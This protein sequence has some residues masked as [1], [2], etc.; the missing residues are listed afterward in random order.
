MKSEN[1]LNSTGHITQLDGI[2]ALAA[3]MVMYFHFFEWHIIGGTFINN[4]IQKTSLY[5]QTGVS[6]FFLLSGF[7]ITRILLSNKNKPD[8]FKNF[9]VKRILRIAPLYYFFLLV[10]YY[11][12][13]Y[14][15][16]GEV[17][18]IKD[19]IIYS[20]YLQNIYLTFSN[21]IKGPG[22]FW[23]LAVEEH[24]YLFWPLLV[25]LTSNKRLIVWLIC[26]ISFSLINRII[27]TSMHFEVF[28]FTLTRLDDICFGS[29]L[30]VIS[31]QY[32]HLI[33]YFKGKI[34]M[35]TSLLYFLLVLILWIFTSG[36]KFFFVQIFKFTF[37][38]TIYFIFLGYSV[39]NKSWL[40]HLFSIKPLVYLGKISYG[41]YVY[42]GLCHGLMIRYLPLKN[43]YLQFFLFF[44]LS[45]L[46][47]ALSF[48]LF[49][50]HFLKLK[51]YFNTQESI[52]NDHKNLIS[53]L[54]PIESI[55]INKK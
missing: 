2:R 13:P 37:I 33:K 35:L 26:L 1:F 38:G 44:G 6:L 5:G 3:L 16:K 18:P 45:I 27:L 8:Y 10:Y 34:I 42:H 17:A 21:G 29:L 32:P 24:F 15:F 19:Q 30:A 52:E 53:V 4:I 47:S 54:S 9:Y 55:I 11:I 28:Y 46:I 40:N 7:L 39:F 31:I 51:R 14:F 50:K 20:T 43:I 41:L 12:T 36:E 22:H 48:E 49:E 23:S 25:F